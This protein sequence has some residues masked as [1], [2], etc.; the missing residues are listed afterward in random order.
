MGRFSNIDKKEF[1]S[2]DETS[3]ESKCLK[4]GKTFKGQV[5]HNI[6]RHY[7]TIHKHKFDEQSLKSSKKINITMNKSEFLK[8]CVGLITVKAMPFR[9]FDDEQY[10][11]RIIQPYEEAF[12]I[13]INSRNI[14]AKLDSCAVEMRKQLSVLLKY[15]LICIKLDTATRMEK[16]ILGINIQLIENFKI[17]VFTLGMIELKKRHTASFLKE[18]IQKCLDRFGVNTTQLY[19]STT[20][21]AANVIKT[22]KLMQQNDAAETEVYD[23]IHNR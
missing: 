21:N 5:L 9:V 15:K 8:C 20:D 1:V 22:S 23:E 18:E 4:C 7:T 12:D 13:K 14:V 10:F 11:Q 19:S 6:K 16:S 2:Y 3:N 17:Q